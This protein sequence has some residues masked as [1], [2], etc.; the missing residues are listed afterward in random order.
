[1]PPKSV[2][3]AVIGDVHDQ[4]EVIDT[5]AMQHLGVD[6]ALFV[7][8]FGNEAVEVVRRVAAVPLPKAVILGNHDA[9][10]TATSWGRRK[11][12]Y[13]RTQED[14][15]QQQ[16]AVL[17]ECHVG[18]GKLDLPSLGLTVV[19]ARPYSWGGPQWKYRRFYRERCGV[20]NFQESLAQIVQ[21]T[22]AA[23]HQTLIFIGHNGPSGLGT[24]PHAPCGRD[25]QPLGGDYG[26]PDFSEAIVKARTLGKQI[27]LVTFGHMHHRLR[28][29]RTRLRQRLMTDDWGTVYLNAAQVP[30]VETTETGYRRSFSLVTLTSGQVRQVRLVWLNQAFEQVTQEV[31]YG[32]SDLAAAAPK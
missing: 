22:E 16:L 17:G 27:P 32:K 8:D 21:A 2:T 30:R 3:I 4:W 29:D 9:W 14:R 25:W 24:A 23:A 7:G 6:L 12:P 5:E 15:L 20:N 13:D 28:H 26:D 31:L 10:Y 18:Y 19:G 1:M 11:C